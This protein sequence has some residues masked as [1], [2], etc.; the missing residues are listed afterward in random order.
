MSLCALVGLPLPTLCIVDLQLTSKFQK[1]RHLHIYVWLLSNGCSEEEWHQM[2]SLL[3]EGQY[4]WVPHVVGQATPLKSGRGSVTCKDVLDRLPLC[5]VL[6]LF[7]VQKVPRVGAR[8]AGQGA[9]QVFVCAVSQPLP[10][11][12]C[13]CTVR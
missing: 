10:P 2:S 5:A 11:A 7:G 4:P 13:A 12:V 1:L 9:R 8:G 3:P 6:M